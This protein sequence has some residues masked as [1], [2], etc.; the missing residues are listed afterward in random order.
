MCFLLSYVHLLALLLCMLFRCS[1]CYLIVFYVCIT[2]PMFVFCYVCSL[3][4]FVCSLLLCYM[5]CFIGFF[6]LFSVCVFCTCILNT[7][8]GWK[9][10]F[11]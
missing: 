8:T 10:N 11:S 7:A 3:F 9:P 4:Y 6:S 2:C 1:V 5:F